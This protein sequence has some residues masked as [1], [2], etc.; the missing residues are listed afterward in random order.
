MWTSILVCWGEATNIYIYKQEHTVV[1][2]KKINKWINRIWCFS[3]QHRGLPLFRKQEAGRE[4]FHRSLTPCLFST[5][6]LQQA[7]QSTRSHSQLVRWWRLVRSPFSSHCNAGVTP[8]FI[9][10]DLKSEQQQK[11][12][13]GH[14][15]RT[16]LRTM[17]LSQVLL[18]YLLSSGFCSDFIKMVC[19]VSTFMFFCL[20]CCLPYLNFQF[21]FDSFFAFPCL[22]PLC[23]CCWFRAHPPSAVWTS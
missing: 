7:V 12:A 3:F 19:F 17:P 9:I 14:I 23:S 20:L 6:P 5:P 4:Y 16:V 13:K 15:R 1:N 11:P 21:Y 2:S 18:W 22:C 10:T 8:P